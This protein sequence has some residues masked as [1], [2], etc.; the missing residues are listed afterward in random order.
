M[1]PSTLTGWVNILEL[2]IKFVQS[3]SEILNLQSQYDD[4]LADWKKKCDDKDKEI[5][6]LKSEIARLKAEIKIL[7]E[8]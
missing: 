7:K 8:R 5:A 6:A 2:V 4:Q 3:R 1:S